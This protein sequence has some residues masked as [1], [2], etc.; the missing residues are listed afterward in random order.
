M[1]DPRRASDENTRAPVTGAACRATC[2][3]QRWLWTSLSLVCLVAPAAVARSARCEVAARLAGVGRAAQAAPPALDETALEALV[4]HI[5]RVSDAADEEVFEQLVAQHS[6][7]GLAAMEACLECV[8]TP[9]ALERISYG[10]AGF[11]D[12]AVLSGDAR[13]FL[14]Q[15]AK[16]G[17]PF[18]RLA[19]TKGLVAFWPGARQQLERIVR[20]H[21]D[22]ACRQVALG[23]LVPGLRLDGSGRALELL[24]KNFRYPLSGSRSAGVAALRAFRSRSAYETLLRYLRDADAHVQTR[25]MIFDALRGEPTQRARDT[26]L[27]LLDSDD[28]Q[29]RFAALDALLDRDE[30]PPVERLEALVSERDARLAS[31]AMRALAGRRAA[32]LASGEEV[33]GA[34]EL[35]R[36]WLRR[37]LEASRERDPLLRAAAA[38]ALCGASGDE[39]HAALA[40]L[41]ADPERDV[42]AA[43]IDGLIQ[44]REAWAIELLIARLPLEEG[45]LQGRVQRSLTL[46]TGVD[47]GRS[48]ARW[49]AFWSSEG[50]HFELPTLAKARASERE[51]EAHRAAGPTHSRRF[52]GLDVR[53]A[54]LCLVLDTSASMLERGQDGASRLERLERE[55]VRLLTELPES[56]R[57]NMIRFADGV[58]L[59]SDR[60]QPLDARSRRSAIAWAERLRAHGETAL[61][62]A[63]VAA[64]EDPE[65]DAIYLLSDGAPTRGQLIDPERVALDIGRR[66]KLRGV[67]IHTLAHGR[68]SALLRRLAAETGGR[69]RLAD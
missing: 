21:P 58:D 31:L 63:M 17:R 28:G 67:V 22:E 45:D 20:G 43:L 44:L 12:D 33:G 51:R 29:L 69:Y 57:V 11:R 53:E 54:R 62:D 48:Q 14:A 66:A 2:A 61:Y 16:Q 24:L 6:P 46:L 9:W 3:V 52:H 7:A 60:A 37:R 36:G 47:H 40:R 64:L 26:L 42:R 19:A 68:G 56:T 5:R 49:A 4:T 41:L 32:T 38:T 23:P 13:D 55:L 10:I 15:R 18:E 65:L 25:G 27:L 50:A 8:S 59:W 39:V 34:P 35:D 30:P 1:S